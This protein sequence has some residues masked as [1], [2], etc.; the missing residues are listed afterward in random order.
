MAGDT[1]RHLEETFEVVVVC[2]VANDGRADVTD[3]D[4]LLFLFKFSMRIGLVKLARNERKNM[5][6]L[7]IF[8]SWRIFY[9]NVA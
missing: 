8:L 5:L 6:C 9:A 3:I 1:E 7:N 4:H 2:S